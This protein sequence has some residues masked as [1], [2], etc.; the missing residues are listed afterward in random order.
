MI[1][2]LAV[3][4]HRSQSCK[5]M[6][7]KDIG[8]IPK[9]WLQASFAQGHSRRMCMVAFGLW[10]LG[11]WSSKWL[12]PIVRKYLV[13]SRLRIAFQKKSWIF[14]GQIQFHTSLFKGTCCWWKR[15]LEADLTEKVPLLWGHIKVSEILAKCATGIPWIRF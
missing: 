8:K 7:K 2:I 15:N 10:H 12:C 13:G 5:D 6:W 4:L 9:D 3:A 1:M 11:Q 14:F